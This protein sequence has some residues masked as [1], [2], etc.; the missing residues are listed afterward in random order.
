MKSSFNKA[1]GKVE[2]K[3]GGSDAH[4]M[5]HYVKKKMKRSGSDAKKIKINPL[6]KDKMI[7]R[8]DEFTSIRQIRILI[9]SWNCN[10]RLKYDESLDD[11]LGIPKDENKPN[12]VVVGFQEVVELKVENIVFSD[13]KVKKQTSYWS[14]RILAHLNS[15]S[16]ASSSSYEILRHHYL[17]GLLMIIF[18]EKDLRKLISYELDNNE[19]VGGQFDN[20]GNKG[21]VSIRFNICDTSLCFVCSHLEAHRENVGERN[22]DYIQINKKIEF[23]IGEEIISEMNAMRLKEELCV[24]NSPDSSSTS[25]VY[26]YDHDFV[27]WFGDLNYR[28]DESASVSFEDVVQHAKSCD[29]KKL[30]EL[31]QLN[32]AKEAGS[33][34][35]GFEE[36]LIN[37]PPTF[38]HKVGSSEYDSKRLPAYCDRILY[39]CRKSEYSDRVTQ[40]DYKRSE[41]NVSDHK[42]ISANF[43]LDIEVISKEKRDAVVKEIESNEIASL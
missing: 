10:A 28:I 3:I 38:K 4:K 24:G 27:F 41:I 43:L 7:S 33:A 23:E 35:H 17:V 9:G 1:K 12:I 40:L 13:S 22:E 39:K 19:A 14:D 8:K 16:E 2:D 36:G 11:W 5:K 42:P 6:I 25:E 34:F 15:S 37:F 30:L 20:L 32:L 21:G 29:F 31:D 18:V 26:I